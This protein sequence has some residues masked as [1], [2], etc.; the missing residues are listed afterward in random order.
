[1]TISVETYKRVAVEDPSGHWELVCGRLRQKPD[2]TIE[3]NDS[4]RALGYRLISQLDH[5][6]FA[7][8]MGQTKVHVAP[9]TYC[10]PDLAVI[11]REAIR[12]KRAVEGGELEVYTEPLPLVVEVW[13]PSTGDYDVETKLPEY[14]RRGDAEIWRLHP[15]ER[16]LTTWRRQA[17]G[18]YSETVYREGVIEPVVALPGVRIN[19]AELF[20]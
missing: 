7:V 10:I 19:L 12:R 5:C 20:A 15:Y 3:H 11:P 16:T 2:M 4:I 8:D 17:D 6:Q 13:L 14:Q 9:D 18:S 1:M